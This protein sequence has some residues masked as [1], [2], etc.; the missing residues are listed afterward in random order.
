MTH[1]NGNA[2]AL[3]LRSL[4]RDLR[5]SHVSVGGGQDVA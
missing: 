4:A 1:L 2:A 5:A 3:P